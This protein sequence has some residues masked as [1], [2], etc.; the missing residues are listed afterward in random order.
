MYCKGA[1]KGTALFAFHPNASVNLVMLAGDFNQWQP[2]TMKKQKDGSFAAVVSL[3]SGGCQYK[4]IVDGRWTVDPDNS[5]W[6]V[7]AY[8]TLNSVARL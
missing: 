8:G 1:K 3:P 6:A 7:N 4:F 2:L 5:S